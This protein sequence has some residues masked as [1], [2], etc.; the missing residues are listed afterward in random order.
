MPR[1]SCAT[2]QTAGSGRPVATDG[3]GAIGVG[4]G[5][6]GA[7]HAIARRRN[8]PPARQRLRRQSRPDMGITRVDAAVRGQRRPRVGGRVGNA[9]QR[10]AGSRQGSTD[11]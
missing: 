1:L 2:L 9:D 10:R 11:A 7:Q 8:W 3:A 4:G 5:A 6:A